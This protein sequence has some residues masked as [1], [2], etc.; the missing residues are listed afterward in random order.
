MKFHIERNIYIRK[1][2]EAKNP[3]R[4][5]GDFSLVQTSKFNM[6]AQ[7]VQS[8]DSCSNCNNLTD[9]FLH[10]KVKSYPIY[11]IVPKN[12]WNIDFW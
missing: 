8:S 11:G 4:K 9:I 5:V 3:S 1:Y 12:I 6:A 7:C 10:S 2:F